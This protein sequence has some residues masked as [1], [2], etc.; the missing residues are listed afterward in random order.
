MKKLKYRNTKIKNVFGAFDSIKEFRRFLKLY[1]AQ[2]DGKIKWL[3]RQ[4]KFVLIPAQRDANGKLI[5]R[6]CSYYADFHYYTS[7]NEEIVEDV[8]S[9]ITRKN[10]EYIIK[11]KLMLSVYGIQIKEI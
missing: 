10:H 5:E 7:D 11:R 3:K 4:H 8:K 6:E 2:K 9:E 1:Q